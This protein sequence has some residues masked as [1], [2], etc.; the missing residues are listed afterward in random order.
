MTVKYDFFSVLP[1]VRIMN[2]NIIEG[3]LAVDFWNIRQCS[4]VK[5]FFLSHF[6][7]D[8]V[9]G[10]TPSW[11][12][13]IYMSSV[14]AKLLTHFIKVRISVSADLQG[15]LARCYLVSRCKTA[16]VKLPLTFKLLRSITCITSRRKC[17]KVY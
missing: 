15:D 6:H 17:H 14:T 10:L 5:L 16:K 7:A 12:Y 2:G 4:M 3:I 13:P 8:H 9:N 11:R 1:P